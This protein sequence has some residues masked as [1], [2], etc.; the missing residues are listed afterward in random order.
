MVEYLIK[1]MELEAFKNTITTGWFD[2][3]ISNKLTAELPDATYA[4][5][6]IG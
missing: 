2:S 5:R 3:L 6:F 4:I 1:L